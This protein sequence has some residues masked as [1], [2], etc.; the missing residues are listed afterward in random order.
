MK[1][2]SVES[3]LARRLNALGVA[4]QAN[5]AWICGRADKVAVGEFAAVSFKN[6]TLKVRVDS[7]ARAYLLRLKQKD[8]ILKINNELKAPR[9]ERLRF[10]ID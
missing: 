6:G 4:K 7:V 3:I 1:Q 5:A 8:L 9:V 10:V 2:E